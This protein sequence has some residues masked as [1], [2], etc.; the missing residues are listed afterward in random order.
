MEVPGKSKKLKGS[1]RQVIPS[2]HSCAFPLTHYPPKQGIPLSQRA[3]EYSSRTTQHSQFSPRASSCV[4]WCGLPLGCGTCVHVWRKAQQSF[5][6]LHTRMMPSPSYAHSSSNTFTLRGDFAWSKFI[7]LH[8]PAVR[9][10]SFK[11]I[12]LYASTLFYK[13]QHSSLLFAVLPSLCARPNAS[14]PIMLY[15][16]TQ[17]HCR[18]NK[19]VSFFFLPPKYSWHYY[20]LINDFKNYFIVSSKAWG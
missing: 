11:S 12:N 4:L 14:Q 5:N 6:C 20:P 3:T 16:D 7:S 13:W 2:D 15:P 18:V 19:V 10:I 1:E 17:L 9:W 8:C